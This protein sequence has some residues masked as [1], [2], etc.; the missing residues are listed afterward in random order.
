MY[1]VYL[2]APNTL[3][4][5]NQ[6]L[7][8]EKLASAGAASDP[9]A[10]PVFTRSVAEGRLEDTSFACLDNGCYI[11]SVARAVSSSAIHWTMSETFN[12]HSSDNLVSVSGSATRELK[13]CSIWGNFDAQPTM[14]PTSTY[15][16][17]MLPTPPPTVIPSPPPT[18][19]PFP[20]PSAQPTIPPTPAPTKTPSQLPTAEPTIP[21]TPLPTLKPS[22]APTGTPSIP[23]TPQPTLTPSQL[24]T[25]IPSPPP[26]QLPTIIPSQAPT[27]V[28]SPPPSQL[29]SIIPSA[30][31][32]FPP[33]P[34]PTALPSMIPT[35]LPSETPTA[36]PTVF[37]S[38]R[39]TALPTWIPTPPPTVFPSMPPT[40]SPSVHCDPG[41][42]L[43]LDTGRCEICDVGSYVNTTKPPWPTFCSVCPPGSVSYTPLPLCFFIFFH[44]FKLLFRSQPRSVLV[45]ARSAMQGN[46]ATLPELH[47]APVYQGSIGITV[48]ARVA[49]LA[50]MPLCLSLGIVSSVL[51]ASV[52]V[53][54]R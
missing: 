9:N 41:E 2:T 48:V 36:L 47:V 13:F 30:L 19:M 52:L 42:Y 46:S 35:P 6:T 34:A 21:P 29:P 11:V 50:V 44:T 39:P 27:V 32:T 3:G 8:I 4:W 10:I 1:R 5:G 14:Y 17:S 54:W 23:P 51:K 26:S 12:N 33:S 28:P 18:H 20:A 40:P 7:Q 24:P 37:P 53:G 16:P 15:V 45:R 22:P 43:D 38:I 31:P 49:Q 25:V